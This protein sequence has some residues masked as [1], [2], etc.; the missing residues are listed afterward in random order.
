[1]I[2]HCFDNK[3]HRRSVEH[4]ENMNGTTQDVYYVDA[5][6]KEP[7]AKF[8]DELASNINSNNSSNNNNNDSIA[9]DS[10]KRRALITGVNGQVGSYLAEFLLNKG[11]SVH[12]MI[13]RESSLNNIRL[14][15]LYD[16]KVNHTRSNFKLHYGDLTDGCSLLRLITIIKPHEIYN[17]AAQSHVKISFEMAEMTGDTNALGTLRLLE[18]IRQFEMTQR[19]CDSTN[20]RDIHKIKFYQASTS[21]LFGGSMCQIPQNESTP[22]HPRS[23]YGCAKLYAH[24]LVVNYREAYGLFGVNGILFNH[25][26]PRRGE[27]FVTR[28]ISRSVAEIKLKRR[29]YI[30]LG[31]LNSRRDWGHARDYV[32]AIWL[33]LQQESPRD[34]VISSDESHSVREFVETAF[35]VIGLKIRW[36]GEGLNERG[37]DSSGTIRVKVS[38]R[39]FRPSEVDHLMGDSSL[40]R[41]HLAWRPKTSFKALVEEMVLSDLELLGHKPAE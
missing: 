8:H 38:A 37:Y 21:E 19:C 35:E 18:A 10:N 6:Y 24:S 40:A 27:N 5:A 20:N 17:L 28:K 39:F 13:R 31:N 15:H 33:M 29:D 14:N 32:E 1:M 34:F 3:V 7:H 16:D 12:G 22:F 41:K 23:P 2:H 30:E 11:Y 4:A 9:V 36:S 25:E 26:S